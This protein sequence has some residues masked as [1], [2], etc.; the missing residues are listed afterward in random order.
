MQ[1]AGILLTFSYIVQYLILTCWS[2]NYLLACFTKVKYD[3]LIYLIS[4]QSIHEL[5]DGRVE[6]YLSLQSPQHPA[7]MGFQYTYTE[8]TQ[9]PQ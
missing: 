5:L 2:S 7:H 3:Y 1:L 6:P 8:C 4:L 9:W